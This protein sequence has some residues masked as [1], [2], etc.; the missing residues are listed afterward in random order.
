VNQLGY[1]TSGTKNARL[2]SPVAAPG[3][4]FEV[5]DQ[6]GDKVMAA[7]VG[8]DRGRWSSS[9]GHVYE[10]DF[11]RL[12]RP[13]TYSIAIAGSVRARSPS[14]R[15]ERSSDLYGPLARSEVRFLRA[16]RDGRD[17]DAAILDR[18]PSHLADRS[19]SVYA[20]PRYRR[21]RLVGGLRRVGGAVDVSGGWMDAGDTLKY[22]ETASFTEAMLLY[23]LRRYPKAF[24]DGLASARAEARFGMD[25]L[26]K[27]WRPRS[28]TL[29]YQVGLGNGN[30]RTIL[31]A[32]DTTWRLPQADDALKGSLGSPAH[33]VKYR[34][35]FRA[36]PPGAALSP[37]LAGRMA[38]AF[39]LGAQEFE[40]LDRAYASR[41]L[42][43]ARTIF[44]RA[45]TRRVR[46]LVTATPH[47]F[48]PE[49][50][51]RDDMELGAAE[52][53]LASAGNRS[54]TRRYLHVAARWA[55]AYAASPLNG[56]D[57]LNLYDV[58][59]L[60]HQELVAAM[61]KAR[62]SEIDGVSRGSLAADLTGQM[63]LAE[64]AAA[65]DPFELG[66]PYRDEDTVSH[67]L[68]FAAEASFL[69]EL[70]GSSR[71]ASFGAAERDI[72]L[73]DNAWGLSFVVGAGS[74]FP[75][76]LHHPVANLT[77]SLD[78]S[79]PL[80]LGAV[81]PGPAKPDDLRG[82]ALSRG[83]RPC[84]PGGGDP[85]ERFSGFGVRYEDNVV[86]SPTN[87]PSLDTAALALLAFSQQAGL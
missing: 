6:S 76:C 85:F 83:Y 25:W 66:Q 70:T 84:P 57:S 53:S 45:A 40:P 2:L 1:A 59:A 51:W 39:A 15:I 61:R 3:A 5:L 35:A 34:P 20:T 48:Y 14:F 55:N 30:G 68:G 44:A 46:G 49:R 24:G 87:E 82:L 23:A 43:A 17:V 71:F 10:I 12:R 31:G 18:R 80:L 79:P 32:H 72:V 81:A 22:A 52:L 67:A 13:G 60:A 19:A 41:C 42:Q 11:S 4:R 36:G 65:H 27:L 64:R 75:H 58:S 29:I 16:Q 69:D 8:R 77:G 38:A 63:R 26:L 86:S 47:D 73:G 21:D 50:E 56:T 37:N 74:D 7:R 33:Y 9:F 28:R 78:G 62:L 54:G